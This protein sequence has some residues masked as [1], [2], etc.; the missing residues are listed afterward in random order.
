[1]PPRILALT[2]QAGL[3]FIAWWLTRSDDERRTMQAAFWKELES[4]AMNWA[5]RASD[6]AAY[7][8]DKYKQTVTV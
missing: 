6:L 8:A 5:K 1:M 4:Q 7:A 3:A 2:A